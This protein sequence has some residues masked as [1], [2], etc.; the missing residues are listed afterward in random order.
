MSIA[1]QESADAARR[2]FESVYGA[3]PTGIWAAPG[4]VNV[5]GEHT[6]YNAGFVLPMGIDRYT[7][8]AAAP[9]LDGV[10]RLVSSGGNTG[11]VEIALTSLAPGAQKDW[12][13][14]PAGV[15]WA[16]GGAGALPAGF[17]G[18]D[19]AYSSAV[20]VGSGLSSSAALECATGLALTGLAGQPISPAE[21]A[22]LTQLAE[23]RY[24]GVPCG[25]LDQLSSAFAA[26]DAVLHIDT[27]SFDIA[28]HPFALRDADLALLVM[29]TKVQHQHGESGYA[30]RRATCERAAEALGVPALRDLA[31]GDLERAATVLDEVS[32]RR[33]RHVVT[34][35]ERVNRF[36]SLL[37][38][39]P[40]EGPRLNSAGELLTASHLSLRDDFEVS[41]AELDTVVDAALRGGAHGARMTGGGFGGCAIA[42]VSVDRLDRVTE[43]VT[44]AL[45]TAELFTVTADRGAFQVY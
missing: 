15:A 40:L 17:T 16:L 13:A 29:N 23:N 27:R 20:P 21:L 4:R 22:R 34:E 35:N 44:D 30:D 37:Q 45:P 10:L 12:T 42:L 26:A 38:L 9:R 24:A 5:I 25:P 19:L 3:A 6:D 39:G 31:F 28:V 18:A 7:A 2:I 8:V 36:V 41:C 14:Y 32:L 1:A 33:V 43:T 11:V